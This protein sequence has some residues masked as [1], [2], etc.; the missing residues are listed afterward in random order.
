MSQ[1]ETDIIIAKIKHDNLKIPNN[2]L[3]KTVQKTK[4]IKNASFDIR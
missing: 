4:E 1:Q 3:Q 2:S